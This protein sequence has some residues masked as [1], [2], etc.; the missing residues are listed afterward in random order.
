MPSIKRPA[1][2]AICPANQPH[3]MPPSAALSLVRS[4]SVANQVLR[5]MCRAYDTR[6]PF[7]QLGL[8]EEVVRAGRPA[9]TSSRR[10]FNYGASRSSWLAKIL[11]A[12]A[13]NRHGQE[14][15]RF[16]LPILT[17]LKTHGPKCPL[18]SSWLEPTRELSRRI[19]DRFFT[20]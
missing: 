19:E 17:L 20:K 2:T 1:Y 18:P 13:Q 3:L 12:A 8:S 4:G 14:P 9:V 15:R 11:S 10:P 5:W 6:M 7:K 16:A